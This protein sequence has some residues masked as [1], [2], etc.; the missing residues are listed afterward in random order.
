MHTFLRKVLS[1]FTA[2]IV[3]LSLIQPVFAS[4]NDVQNHWAKDAIE[5]LIIKGYPEGTFKPQ[6]PITR[7]EFVTI[8]NSLLKLRNASDIAYKDVK[9]SDW[10]YQQVRLA[11]NYMNGYPDLTFRPN[12]PLTRQETVTILDRV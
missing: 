11:S 5:R 8:I 10:Y 12:K 1:L 4:F 6:N 7:V 2:V 3:V 9:Q